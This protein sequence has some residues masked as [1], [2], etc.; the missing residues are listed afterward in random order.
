MGP[1]VA[2]TT[3]LLGSL[4]MTPTSL[5]LGD[6]SFRADGAAGKPSRTSDIIAVVTVLLS[7]RPFRTTSST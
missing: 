5:F 4:L 6:A 7:Q 2:Q 1:A 3:D